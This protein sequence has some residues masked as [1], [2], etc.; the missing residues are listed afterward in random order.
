MKTFPAK[1]TCFFPFSL[2]ENQVLVMSTLIK[3]IYMKK[4]E[5]NL[6]YTFMLGLIKNKALQCITLSFL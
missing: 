5:K 1:S 4:K 3:I 2:S 6:G